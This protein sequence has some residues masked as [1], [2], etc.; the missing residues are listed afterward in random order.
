MIWS[1]EEDA[2]VREMYLTSTRAEI[3]V[4][5]D[6]TEGMVRSRCWT[7]GLNS[8][9]EEW[10]LDDVARL[11]AICEAIG[12]RGYIDFTDL[13]RDFGRSRMAVRLKIQRLGYGDAHRHKIP[14]GER[15]RARKFS[16]ME[17]VRAAQ[18]VAVKAR[19]ARDGH[20]RGMLGR[21]HTEDVIS[22]ISEA[23]KRQW[24]DPASRLNSAE[25]RQVKSD[26]LIERIASGKMRSGYSRGAGGRRADLGGIYVRSAWEANYVRYLNALVHQGTICCWEYEPKTFVF[27][28][29]AR[30]TRA[31]TPDFR[32][33][34]HDGRREWHEVKGWMDPNSKARLAKM[35][36]HFPNERVILI[37]EVWFRE[38]KR[39]RLD[40]SLPGWEYGGKRARG[41]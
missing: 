4:R 2:I 17:E 19:W 21:K 12:P 13:A 39:L 29:V 5:L 27:E 11:R 32:V 28:G 33:C 37:D 8:K 15:P 26:R 30:G 40:E 38:A 25:S 23:S 3:A 24:A 35:S 18:S 7:L 16:T 14:G 22:R 9:V 1:R 20:P 41:T 6:R 36:E 34:F 31:Y 10:P